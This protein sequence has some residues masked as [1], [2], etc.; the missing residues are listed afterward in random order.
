VPGWRTSSLVLAY[1]LPRFDSYVDADGGPVTLPEEG[2]GRAATFVDKDGRHIAALVHDAA[3]SHQPD[4]LEVVC[5]AANVALERERLQAELGARVVELQASRERIVAA[6]DAE[7]RRLER[8][9][10]DGAQQRLVAIALQLRLLQGHVGADP[11]AEEPEPT[12]RSQPSP[13]P[14]LTR[15]SGHCGVWAY[16][17]REGT[18]KDMYAEDTHHRERIAQLKTLAGALERLAPS[19]A[20]DALLRE[21]HHRTVLLDTGVP[22]SSSW[23]DQPENDPRALFE[24]M[25]LPAFPRFH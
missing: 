14:P 3:L 7:R 9:L 23:P 13:A 6:G 16:K 12:S 5:A 10:H 17:V 8:N 24:H 19:S 22:P 2:S 1:W 15:R 4:L 21:A 20:R 11:S 25:T 18:P